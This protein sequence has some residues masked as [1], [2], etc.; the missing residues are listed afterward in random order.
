[1]TKTTFLI[2]AIAMVGISPI[3]NANLTFATDDNL[4]GGTSISVT[5]DSPNDGDVIELTGPTVDVNVDGKAS[6]GTGTPIKDTTVVYILDT[7]GSMNL[8][9]GNNCDG[10]GGADSRITCAKIG[11]SEA[12]QAAAL[13]N[14]SV[15]ETGLGT[16][17]SSGIVRDVN[18]L[19]AGTQI[20]VA[21]DFD[22]NGNSTPDIEDVVNGLSAG[23]GTNYFAGIQAANS[24][25]VA[26][27]NNNAIVIFISDGENFQGSPVN[28]FNTAGFPSNTVIKSFAVGNGVS[29]S[30]NSPRGDLDDVAALGDAGS[31]CTEITD[32]SEL[33]NAITQSIGSELT[34]VE[35][36]VNSSGYTAADNI[37]PTLPQNGPASVVYAHLATGL[38]AGSH[39]ICAR[40]SGNDAGGNGNVVECVTIL[41]NTPPDCSAVAASESILWPPN[42]KL[43]KV[44]L[45]GAV[46]PDGG[47]ITLEVIGVLQDEP[48]NGLGDGDDSPDA[49]IDE[50][51]VEL[52]AERSGNGDVKDADGRIYQV[53]FMATDE[54]GATC[55]GSVEIGVPHDKKG[56]PINSG[57]DYDS[58]S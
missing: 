40:A 17:S 9:S 16:F 58:T 56:T 55:S 44:T 37:V 34:D 3:L 24:I 6:I 32:M 18:L 10:L 45:S 21:P 53:S 30:N 41:V 8:S 27:A 48:T 4:P 39:E 28:T 15:E 23:G 26:T 2:I 13:P 1:M 47:D 57:L 25:L 33:A 50:D 46:D 35:L 54:V 5:I 31:V 7:S 49:F 29:C 11:I 20:L 51:S 42:H 43:V 52:R 38:G 19:D 36:D 14:S 12:N 22:G